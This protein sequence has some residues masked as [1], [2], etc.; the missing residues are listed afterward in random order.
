VAE[1]VVAVLDPIR[2]RYGELRGNP[3]ELRSIL[4]DGAAKAETIASG[5]LRTV[6]ERVGLV[7]P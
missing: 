6:Y 7:T 5:T 1:A 4:A 3:E 2:L